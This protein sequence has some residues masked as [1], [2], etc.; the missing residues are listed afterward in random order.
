MRK[1]Y[2]QMLGSFFSV[3]L[4]VMVMTVPFII[5]REL[6]EVEARSEGLT[7]TSTVISQSNSSTQYAPYYEL[8]ENTQ[9]SID[10]QGNRFDSN[11]YIDG[12]N[13]YHDFS[14]I[15]YNYDQTY[16]D[17]ITLPESSARYTCFYIEVEPDDMLADNI[18]QIHV[19]VNSST[20]YYMEALN[21]VTTSFSYELTDERSLASMDYVGHTGEY[22]FQYTIPAGTLNTMAVISADEDIDHQLIMVKLGHSTNNPGSFEIEIQINP[23]YFELTETIWN[24]QTVKTY[25]PYILTYSNPSTWTEIS[26]TVTGG[27]LAMIAGLISPIINIPQFKVW[28]FRK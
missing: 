1:T 24:N 3:V 21:Y 11:L 25:E 4:L 9:G 6:S 16:S 8:N 28:R 17:M 14:S 27:A 15:S 22:L 23:D 20:S 2:Q 7:E 10:I 19:R 12:S 26:L 5:S 18:D 13:V